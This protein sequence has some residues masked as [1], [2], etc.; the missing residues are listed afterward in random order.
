MLKT[1]TKNDKIIKENEKYFAEKVVL[2][3]EPVG[4]NRSSIKKSLIGFGVPS[5]YIHMAETIQD[6]QRI[7]E[8]SSPDILFV[9]HLHQMFKGE[10]LLN[11]HLK[12]NPNRLRASFFF[13]T[14]DNSASSSC[15]TLEKE[16]DGILVTPFTIESI[17]STILKSLQKKI[18]PTPYNRTIE[19]GKEFIFRGEK[20]QALTFFRTAADMNK[21]PVLAQYFISYLIKDENLAEAERLLIQNIEMNP[22]HYKSLSLLAD[23]YDQEKRYI[24]QYEIEGKILEHFPLNPEKIPRLTKLSIINRKYEDIFNYTKVFGMIKNAGA[25]IQTYVAAGLAT[26]GRFLI[27]NGKLEDGEKAIVKSAKLCGGKIP[28]LLN[29]AHSLLK[30]NKKDQ[31]VQLYIS[32][33]SEE[34]ENDEFKV[35]LFEIESFEVEPV[36]IF[37]NARKAYQAGLRDPRIYEIALRGLRD[38]RSNQ[39]EIDKALG[40]AQKF[41]PGHSWK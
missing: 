35:G 31:A 1:Q 13:I 32:H 37:T 28:I 20:D 17:N 23:I 6:A 18:H 34:T 11:I 38:G 8:A 21:T 16:I 36:Q 3:L 10:D 41:F 15:L 19:E 14:D 40:E 33:A 27:E 29:L 24:E 5:G 4:M 25:M 26:C 22:K 12:S 30:M 7:I 39:T 2:I 9:R